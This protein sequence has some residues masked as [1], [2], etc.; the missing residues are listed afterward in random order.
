MTLQRLN[1]GRGHGYK[2]DGQKVDGVTTL[3]SGGLPKPALMYWSAKSVAEYVADADEQTLTTLRSLGR[4]GMVGALKEIPWTKRDT[5]AAK[6]T[7][8]HTLAEKLG[9][10]EEVDVPEEIAGY[11]E[12]AVAFLDDYEVR[13]LAPLE[14]A[15]GSRKWRYGGTADL[16][17]EVRL[18]DGT[19]T[20]AVLDYKTGASGIWPDIT[21]Q[22]AAYRNAEVYLDADGAEQPMADLNLSDIAYGVW[23]RSD[24]YDVYPV[25]VGEPQFKFFCHLAYVARRADKNGELKTWLGAA[26]PAVTRQDVTA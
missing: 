2:L 8:V 18:P 11:V 12:S 19:H 20:R 5:A 17:A 26:L 22:L 21:P 23:L 15:L 9:A 6:G 13:P 14:T 4:N 7:H 3:I 24:G 10:G 25:R 1:Y 16:I